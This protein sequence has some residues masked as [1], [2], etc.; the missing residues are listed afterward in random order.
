MFI[1]SCIFSL[2]IQDLVEMFANS[3]D[4]EKLKH[5]WVEWRKFSG[6]KY[7]KQYL[8]FIQLQNEKAQSLGM[9]FYSEFAIF[10]D[11]LEEEKALEERANISFMLKHQT[12]PYSILTYYN[13]PSIL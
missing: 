9:H 6:A 10:L 3:R 1:F 7:R 4:Y 12:N 5:A 13:F 2:Q 11:F 8:E